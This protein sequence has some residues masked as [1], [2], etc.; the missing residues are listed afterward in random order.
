MSSRAQLLDP[1][2][3]SLESQEFD[4]SLRARIVGQEE[5]V[6]AVVDLYQVFTAGMN[7]PGTPGGKLPFPGADR[8]GKDAHRGSHGRNPCSAIRAP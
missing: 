8:L 2:L 3:R 6:R 5:A 4:T 7:S 1:Q